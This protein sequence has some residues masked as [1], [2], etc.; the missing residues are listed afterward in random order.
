MAYTALYRKYRPSEFDDVKGQ[1]HIVTTLQNQVRADR[2]GHAY[3]FCGTRG[4]GKT[5]V[6][7]ILAKAVNCEHPVNGS[8]CGE[9]AMCRAITAG[10]SLNV[11]EIDAASNNGVDDVRQIREEVG[12]PPTQGRFKVYIIDEV[13]MLSVNAFNALLKTLEEPPSY[14]VFILA[15]T[16]PHKLPV[17]ILSRCQRYD[18]HRIPVD[19]I[20][21]RLQE[22]IGIE[23][24]EAEE[25]AIRYIARAAD[26]S[27]RDGLSLLDQCVSFYLGQKLTYE[28]V[29]EVLG[30]VD[31]TIFARLLEAVLGDRA[32]DAIA[33]IEDLVRQG[34]DLGQFVND[35]IWYLRNLLLVRASDRMEDVLDMSAENLAVL[36]AEAEQVEDVTVMRYIRVFSDLSNEMRYASQKRVLLE[37]AVLRLCRPEMEQD[38][39]SLLDRIA[40]LERKMEQGA[41]VQAR[42]AAVQ[43][44]AEEPV[45]GPK[46][47]IPKALP[48]EIREIVKNWNRIRQAADGLVKA[49][50][51]NAHLSLTSDNKLM[52]VFEDGMEYDMMK[53]RK[54]ELEELIGRLFGKEVEIE[55]KQSEPGIRFEEHY[56]DLKDLEDQFGMDIEIEED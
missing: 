24:I 13:H 44:A 55:I 32:A 53:D 37:I 10:N 17:T 18:F 30:A 48:E 16:E 19:T 21:A 36:R 8:P 39:D 45:R 33:V 41:F 3:L 35:F 25:S 56:I 46:P 1:D 52:L 31:T 40:R 51:G 50:L 54:S 2:I 26:G 38:N 22:L 14:V 9:C 47:E 29:L 5:T 20:A 4:T 15:T 28:H 11:I 7:K 6:A 49:Y 42:P 12:Y 34:R 23:G 27:M 43:A